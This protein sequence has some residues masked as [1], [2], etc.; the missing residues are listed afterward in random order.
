MT[1]VTVLA[2]VL[3]VLPVLLRPTRRLRLLPFREHSIDETPELRYQSLLH[4]RRQLLLVGE[5]LRTQRIHDIGTFAFHSELNLDRHDAPLIGF[6]L[7]PSGAKNAI[8]N[9]VLTIF[10]H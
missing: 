6:F 4:V 10:G 8:I 3:R 2:L 7:F 9:N 5:N 1:T